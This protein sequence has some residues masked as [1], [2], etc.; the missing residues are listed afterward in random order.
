[1]PFWSERGESVNNFKIKFQIKLIAEFQSPNHLT[2]AVNL[3]GENR[4]TSALK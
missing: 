3:R 4:T 2:L 1:M